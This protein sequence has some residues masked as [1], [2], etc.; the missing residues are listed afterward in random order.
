MKSSRMDW[1]EQELTTEIDNQSTLECLEKLA[2]YSTNIRKEFTVVDEWKVLSPKI[3]HLLKSYGACIRNRLQDLSVLEDYL[4]APLHDILWNLHE[5]ANDFWKKEV[6]IGVVCWTVLIEI[7]KSVP[8]NSL[9]DSFLEKL[10]VTVLQLVRETFENWRAMSEHSSLSKMALFICKL[11]KELVDLSLDIFLQNSILPYLLET[12]CKAMAHLDHSKLRES[13]LECMI[14]VSD[15]LTQ[16]VAVACFETP[17]LVGKVWLD[18]VDEIYSKEDSSN[19]I[20][21]VVLVASI[22]KYQVASFPNTKKKL[23]NSL[24]ILF[25]LC[26]LLIQRHSGKCRMLMNNY[27]ERNHLI[28]SLVL[29]MEDA[30]NSSCTS[31]AV[32]YLFFH[33]TGNDAFVRLLCML[34]VKHVI[35]RKKIPNTIFNDL[36]RKLN[37]I[38]IFAELFDCKAVP[39]HLTLLKREC[40]ASNLFTESPS[41]EESSKEETIIGSPMTSSRNGLTTEDSNQLDFYGIEEFRKRVTSSYSEYE[42]Y[43]LLS[44][45]N[46]QKLSPTETRASLQPIMDCGTRW[47]GLLVLFISFIKSTFRK[48]TSLTRNGV[49]HHS[50]LFDAYCFLVLM[51]LAAT[52]CRFAPDTCVQQL[53]KDPLLAD[54]LRNTLLK[55]SLMEVPT[56]EMEM[57]KE[58]IL[59]KATELNGT[60]KPTERDIVN[61]D[62]SVRKASTRL[63]LS[64]ILEWTETQWEQPLEQVWVRIR[65]CF[66]ALLLKESR[67]KPVE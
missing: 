13:G 15:D 30:L 33:L 53:G 10:C 47:N 63:L 28:T 36:Q 18:S 5:L 2:L 7:L 32:D 24:C 52:F 65:Q 60:R 44:Y 46:S 61:L 38:M 41:L 23:E 57:L 6:N 21:S 19:V 51:Q 49:N 56:L 4:L 12:W 22:L 42:A 14:S 45:L 40:F 37:E 16:L 62:H 58:T 29:L 59:T 17:N 3:R 67:N 34:V 50:V 39:L 1:L 31:I 35:R 9:Q 54:C 43:Y 55:E 64:S 26:L 11:F 66:D 48:I 27:I 20:C 25:H 8:L